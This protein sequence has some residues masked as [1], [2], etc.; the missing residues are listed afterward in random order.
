M[1]HRLFRFFDETSISLHPCPATSNFSNLRLLVCVCVKCAS[2]KNCICHQ[3]RCLCLMYNW[4]LKQDQ[5]LRKEY[6]GNDAKNIEAILSNGHVNAHFQIL[7]REL[8]ILEPKLPEDIYRSYLSGI[9]QIEH[10]SARAN[11]AASFVSGFVNAGFG[12]DKLMANTSDCWVYKNKVFFSSSPKAYGNHLPI[13]VNF[14]KLFLTA[15]F[16]WCCKQIKFK[17]KDI[18]FLRITECCRPLLLLAWYTCGTSMAVWF[19]L[20]S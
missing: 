3:E 7:A 8:D 6:N 2:Y 5:P 12:Q 11:L 13:S 20:T 16:L 19:L 10:D 4:C 18:F 15:I 14:S 9:R 1:F 17:C